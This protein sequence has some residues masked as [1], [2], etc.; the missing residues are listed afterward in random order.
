SDLLPNRQML[1]IASTLT[2]KFGG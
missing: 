2:R 1:E